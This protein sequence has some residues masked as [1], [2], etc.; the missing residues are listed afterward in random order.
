MESKS[1]PSIF[2]LAAG[3]LIAFAQ[4]CTA[5]ARSL[6]SRATASEHVN[7]EGRSVT[8]PP[9]PHALPRAAQLRRVAEALQSRA[10]YLLGTTARE[11]EQQRLKTRADNERNAEQLRQVHDLLDRLGAPGE[12]GAGSPRER[13][14][15][16]IRD[17][18]W[19]P[20]VTTLEGS[21]RA[22]SQP[23]EMVPRFDKPL[24]SAALLA[25][26][27]DVLW[28]LA[29]LA[30]VHGFS[31]QAIAA[32]N[33]DKLRKRHGGAFKPHA[34][35]KRDSFANV[36]DGA[37]KRRDG[38]DAV[39]RLP[40]MVHNLLDLKR[41]KWCKS[42]PGY[43]CV[44]V[45]EVFVDEF[46]RAVQALHDG[47]AAGLDVMRPRSLE[48]AAIR[49]ERQ[50][51]VDLAVAHD[52][53]AGGKSVRLQAPEGLWEGLNVALNRVRYSPDANASPCAEDCNCERC[54]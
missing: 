40:V 6:D 19:T 29:E 48:V 35:Q 47:A 2:E 52:F 41:R 27:G 42:S 45:L 11:H 1:A 28:Y 33:I 26:L 21:D 34:E 51:R 24:D 32:A 10:V 17:R 37:R 46:R 25:E 8:R 3:E 14:F 53:D 16:L 13:L 5:M 20:N 23:F 12:R 9:D 31:L 49:F 38:S 30:T 4:R 36:D 7:L 18:G 43:D 39:A 44:R 15:Y 22:T 54:R 50:M